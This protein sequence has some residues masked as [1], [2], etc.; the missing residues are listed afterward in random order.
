MFATIG[1]REWRILRSYLSVYY[2]SFRSYTKLL[3]HRHSR[4]TNIYIVKLSGVFNLI[5]QTFFAVKLLIEG[6]F[7]FWKTYVF[8]LYR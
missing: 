1:I 4:K 2:R 5:S 3:A 8:N 7:R 6:F